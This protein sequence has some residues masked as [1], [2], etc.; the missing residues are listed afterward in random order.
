MTPPHPHPTL[1]SALADPSLRELEIAWSDPYGRV[2][3][4]RLPAARYPQATAGRGIGFCDGS[5][6]WNAAGEVQPAASLGAP[7]RGYPDA[8]AVPDPATY[9]PLPWR[10]GAGQLLSDIHGHDGAPSPTT[11]RAL[12]RRTLEHLARLGYTARAAL[13]LEVYLLHPD[14][15]PLS[16]GLHAYSLELANELDPLLSRFT[17]ELTAYVPIE[18]VLTEYGPGQAELN[19]AHQDALTAADDAF[20]LRYAVRELARREGLLATFMAKPL[21]GQSGNSAHIHLSLWQDGRPAFAPEAGAESKAARA[22]VGGLVRHLPAVTFYGAPTVNSYKRFEPGG[23]A[24]HRADWGG[25]DRSVAVRSLVDTPGSS[26]VELRT[27]GADANP[28]IALAAALAAVVAGLEDGLDLP[29]PGLPGEP[30]KLLPGTLAAAT[31]AARADTR[32]TALLGEDFVRD[33]TALADSEWH[34]YTTEVTAW[35]TDRYLRNL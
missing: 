29:A 22:A 35:E 6:A 18:S 23:F 2:Q 26:R 8:Y 16:Q 14:G 34:A 27:P 3:G 17:D 24:P 20:R 10:P 31:A 21:G 5:L 4:K 28:Y 19:L 9:R 7:D 13:E 15:T 30:A 25:D 1:E 11:P 12:L 32:L 33:C